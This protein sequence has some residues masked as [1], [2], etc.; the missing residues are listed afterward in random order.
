MCREAW[1]RD[2]HRSKIFVVLRCPSN[3]LVSASNCLRLARTFEQTCF[4]FDILI[5]DKQKLPRKNSCRCAC[6]GSWHLA[7]NW[8][9]YV[10]ESEHV[11]ECEHVWNICTSAW[12]CM[13]MQAIGLISRRSEH[14]PDYI[15]SVSKVKCTCKPNNSSL[16]RTNF[17]KSKA[18]TYE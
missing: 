1:L 13:P 15:C 14:L 10:I 4:V 3:H 7:R 16:K 5:E 17:M 9:E 11:I 8:S 18:N 12:F 2:V 6:G